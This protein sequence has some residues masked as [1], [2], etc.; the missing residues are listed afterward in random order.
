M[1]SIHAPH[2][3]S[4]RCRP[5]ILARR[6]GFNPRPPRGER[7]HSMVGL[8]ERVQF[9]STPPTRGATAGRDPRG[10]VERVSIH[11]PHA[12]SDT[13]RRTKEGR[14]YMFQ[15]TP[16]TRGATVLTAGSPAP[17][18]G[19]N[20]RPPR[21][22]RRWPFVEFCS[23]GV[24]SIHAPHAGSDSRAAC[25]C[26]SYRCFNPRPPRGERLARRSRARRC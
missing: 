16:P 8:P 14:P 25:P 17:V 1:V 22:E 3:G 23:M 15:S 18:M 7:Q 5:A 13:G 12:G 2:A 4:D 19:F 6:S 26:R 9:Q 20:P 24:V 21:G 10:A 11:A